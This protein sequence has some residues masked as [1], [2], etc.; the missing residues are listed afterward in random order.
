MCGKEIK[1][2]FYQRFNYREYIFM[3]LL[4][5]FVIFAIDKRIPANYVIKFI[6]FYN[7]P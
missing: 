7:H 2:L 5:R 6:F 3:L 1:E 4:M